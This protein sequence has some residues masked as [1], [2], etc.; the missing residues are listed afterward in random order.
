MYSCM[1]MHA[2]ICINTYQFNEFS[3]YCKLTMLFWYLQWIKI[4]SNWY[5]VYDFLAARTEAD[6]VLLHWKAFLG[7][8]CVSDRQREQYEVIFCLLMSLWFFF[9]VLM[10]RIKKKNTRPWSNFLFPPSSGK[11]LWKAHKVNKMLHKIKVCS[12]NPKVLNTFH[13]PAHWNSFIKYVSLV[14]IEF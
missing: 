12:S 14:N 6:L 9:I 4:N 3:K 11:E 8:N 2:H 13:L 7:L 1:C 10:P 5:L